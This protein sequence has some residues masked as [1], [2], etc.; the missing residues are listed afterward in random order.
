MQGEKGEHRPF[1]CRGD[2]NVVAIATN[3]QRS[4][5]RELDQDPVAST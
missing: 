3:L 4:E 2:A 5:D 1:L